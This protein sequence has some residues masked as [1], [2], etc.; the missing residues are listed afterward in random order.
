MPSRWDAWRFQAATWAL[1]IVWIG[2]MMA[3]TYDEQ[4]QGFASVGAGVILLGSAV[5]QKA[6][7]L[8]AGLVMWAVGATLL[9][10]GLDDLL[11]TDD[12]PLFALIAV[13]LGAFLVVRGVSQKRWVMALVGIFVALSGLDSVLDKNNIP[14][15]AVLVLGFGLWLLAR[16]LSFGKFRSGPPA[17]R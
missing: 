2:L 6:L 7:R 8:E 3:T 14:T 5:V 13:A 17:L 12:L 15:T 11:G 9:L 10:V 16:A 4:N 1:L